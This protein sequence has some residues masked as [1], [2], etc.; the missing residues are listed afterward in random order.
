MI[1]PDREDLLKKAERIIKENIYTEN[2]YPWS[3]YRMISDAAE[4]VV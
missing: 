1:K 3:P 2:K 4:K